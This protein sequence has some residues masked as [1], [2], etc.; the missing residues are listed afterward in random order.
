M[1]TVRGPGRLLA[2]LAAALA[3]TVALAG[4]AAS[5]D[6]GGL[7]ASAPDQGAAERGGA[8]DD[9]EGGAAPEPA[10]PGGQAGGS[11]VD[12]RS[13]IYTGE[14]WIRVDRVDA[15]ARR[16]TAL[17]ERHGGFVGGDR[18][19]SHGHGAEAA[20]VLRI[21]SENFTAAVDQIADLGEEE[22]RTIDT[23]DVTEEVVDLATRIA[24][25]EASVERTRELLERANSIS[26]IVAVEK[27]LSTR[28][29]RLASL[30][31]RQRELADLTALSTI[32]VGLVQVVEE[33]DEEVRELQL[34]FLPGLNAGWNAFV[35]TVTVLVTIF[36]A[37]LPWLVAAAVPTGAVVWWA[38]RR[39]NAPAP[40]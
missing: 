36:G 38:R 8:A 30:Q 10:D 28:E 1:L 25:A 22:S 2:G 35:S 24:T 39:R 7:D 27:E 13:I 5:D 32:T 9:A 19:S 11:F 31:A 6:D 29:A 21:P 34:G 20:I 33:E 37:L 18:R 14:I 26:D 15:T 40:S 17:A 16:V 3:A 23:E 4:C 12:T